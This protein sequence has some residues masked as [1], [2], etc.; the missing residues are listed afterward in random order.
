V[1][2]AIEEPSVADHTLIKY[3]PAAAA[4]TGLPCWIVAS[5]GPKIAILVS[6]LGGH[7]VC[8]TVKSPTTVVVNANQ[9]TSCVPAVSFEG[10][11]VSETGPPKTIGTAPE[12]L[13]IPLSISFP[14]CALSRLVAKVYG[15][16]EEPSVADHTLM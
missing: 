12:A 7:A 11:M 2:G 13:F 15:A 6:M 3:V 5:F 1:Y 16:I 4:V 8:V 14:V 9:S 10:A